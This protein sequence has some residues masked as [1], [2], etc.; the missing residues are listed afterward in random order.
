MVADLL[1]ARGL[2]DDDLVAKIGTEIKKLEEQ[3]RGEFS[4]AIETESSKLQ[5]QEQE[6]FLS[7]QTQIS[8]LM[9]SFTR[10]AADLE[11]TKNRLD[12]NV[13]T[14]ETTLKKLNNLDEYVESNFSFFESEN[15]VT[16]NTIRDMTNFSYRRTLEYGKLGSR[17]Q[18]KQPFSIEENENLNQKVGFQ[19]ENASP[20]KSSRLISCHSTPC[21]N[22]KSNLRKR[23]PANETSSRNEGL[24]RKSVSN[25]TVWESRSVVFYKIDHGI[26]G[27]SLKQV[28]EFMD[29]LD[30]ENLDNSSDSDEQRIF[31]AMQTHFAGY[32]VLIGHHR[33]TGQKAC[34]EHCL[35]TT[36]GMNFTLCKLLDPSN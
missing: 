20:L 27:M 11:E 9:E 14:S 33:C 36:K 1:K 18:K 25:T 7:Q 4:Q 32:E 21:S 22:T 28:K 34:I 16:K 35:L 15:I 26:N 5:A 3:L 2:N 12:Q 19:Q 31:S 10:H 13:K 24:V 6:K 23:K 29:N 30:N 8:Q 17:P